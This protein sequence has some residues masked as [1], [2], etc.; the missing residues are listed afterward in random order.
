MFQLTLR[1]RERLFGQGIERKARKRGFRVRTCIRRGGP[2][3][4]LLAIGTQVA[5]KYIFA[6]LPSV[7][8]KTFSKRTFYLYSTA[9]KILLTVVGC[10][11]LQAL[12]IRNR[13]K[14]TKVIMGYANTLRSH[15]TILAHGNKTSRRHRL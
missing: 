1:I 9:S 14:F 6:I 15:H 4:G 7:F 3:R 10:G 2:T 13:N 12:Y 5:P 8:A 11:L